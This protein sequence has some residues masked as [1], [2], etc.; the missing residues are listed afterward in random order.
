MKSKRYQDYFK[1]IIIFTVIFMSCALAFSIYLSYRTS[2]SAAESTHLTFLNQQ[3]KNMETHFARYAD[4]ILFL[5]DTPPIQGIIRAKQEGG[6]DREEESRQESWVKRLQQIFQ[7]LGERKT[8]HLQIRYIDEKGSEFVRVDFKDG[9]AMVIPDKEIQNKAEREYFK[10]TIKLSKGQVY[11]SRIDLNQE[12]G[13]IVIPYQPTLRIAT[14]I[15]NKAGQ[16]RGILVSNINPQGLL[17]SSELIKPQKGNEIYIV[18]QDGFYVHHDSDPEREWGSPVDLNTGRNLN[19]GQSDLFRKIMKNDTGMA[20]SFN[21]FG[22]VLFSRINFPDIKD[23]YLVI[24]SEIS[25]YIIL[26]PMFRTIIVILFFSLFFLIILFFFMRHAVR[27]IQEKEKELASS[28]ERFRR[29]VM[30]AAFPIMIHAE[31]GEVVQINKAWEEITGYALADIP[32]IS[33]W[34]QKAYGEKSSEVKLYIDTIYS[35]DTR[36]NEGEYVIFTKNGK[37]LVWDFAS[38]PLGSLSDGRRS[39]VSMARDVTEKKQDEEQ[40]KTIL[41][42]SMDGFCITD[43]QG[44]FIDVNDAYC[45]LIGY[46]RDEL[47]NMSISDVEAHEMPEDTARHI[48]TIM[49][50]GYDRFET[51]HQSKNGRLIDIEVRTN[52]IPIKGG[53]FFA[54]F[55]D[56]MERK[57]NEAVLQKAHED[58]EMKVNQRTGAL[59]KANKLLD[60]LNRAQSMFIS[61]TDPKV[62]FDGV[63]QNILALTDSQ[64]GFMGEVLLDEQGAPYFK[65]HAISNIAWNEETQKYY[66][67]HAPCGMEF[68]NLKSL[69][70]AIL[71]T[72]QPVISNNPVNDSRSCGLPKGHPALDAFL[73]IPLYKG[74]K[75]VGGIGIANRPHGYD[76]KLVDYL[77]P[78]CASS[79]SIIQAYRAE[80][81]R[82]RAVEEVNRNYN[83]QSSLS[84]ILRTSL[85]HIPLEEILSTILKKV[86]KVPWF[87]FEER[88]CIFLVEDDPDILVLKAHNNLS[89]LAIESCGRVPVGKCHCGKA[90]LTKKI[91]FANHLDVAHEIRY[92]GMLPH[93]DY[94]VPILLQDKVIG[95]LNVHVKD[96]HHCD[97]REGKFLILVANTIAAIVVR[98]RAEES[99]KHYSED[100]EQKVVMRTKE[101]ESAKLEAEAA[102]IAKSDFLASMSHEL[103]TPLNAIIGFSQVLQAGYF[104]TLVEKQSEYVEDILE[105]GHHLLSLINDILDL[106]KVEA[107][108]ME[109]ALSRVNLANLLKNSLVM[110]KEKAHNHGIALEL[111][112]PDPMKEIKIDADERKLKQIMFNFLSNA[113]KFTPDGGKIAVSARLVDVQ[114]NVVET[115]TNEETFMEICVSDTGIGI[116]AQDQARVFEPFIQVKGGMTG[117]SAGTGLGLSLTKEF[118]ALHKGRIRVESEG[119]G[120]G[121]RFYVSLPVQAACV[122]EDSLTEV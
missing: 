99:L 13:K 31:D 78:F 100:L 104:G 35:R 51:Q 26:A 59:A 74:E 25:P 94:S 112:L 76:E 69:F 6:Y 60:A 110:V 47:L 20:F 57:N 79:A 9:K 16:S 115:I 12:Q 15:F 8:E 118:A 116:A 4:D 92:E 71:T 85:E 29:A 52:F 48:Q 88:G 111:N 37:R 23:K 39:V 67:Q 27:Q 1:T 93:G 113:A 87:A 97:K 36:N 42:T 2:I 90:M 32:T 44:C 119:L 84:D 101:L 38:A 75:F 83:I 49:E 55:R 30:D 50:T 58:L 43:V 103:R 63:L 34:T 68:R 73:G 19:T 65:T 10:E 61:E 18:D 14:P 66:E 77:Q 107:G 80:K 120:K 89:A 109:L 70:G 53:L 46:T 22:F 62:L 40:Y 121:S 122:D 17:H 98:K 11:F 106:S 28:E 24:V 7:S 95:V 41:Q 72:G 108:K 105:S 96:G 82:K 114:D 56:I 33:D 21:S 117:K 64:Y 3:D 86:L 54:F 45:D 91:E 5:A 102:N 81:E